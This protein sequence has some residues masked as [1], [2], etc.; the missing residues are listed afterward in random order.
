MALQGLASSNLFLC[1]SG[2]AWGG[3]AF[4]RREK[5]N[6]IR[7]KNSL[8]P[9]EDA[10]RFGPWWPRKTPLCGSSQNLFQNLL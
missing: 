1:S 10:R 9:E 8:D 5:Q 4:G 7:V 2:K 3:L 6:V